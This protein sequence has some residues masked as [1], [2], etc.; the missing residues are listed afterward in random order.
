MEKI[1]NDLFKKFEKDKINMCRTFGGL[2]DDSTRLINT[3][4]HGP[5]NCT[6]TVTTTYD[7]YGAFI[8]SCENWICD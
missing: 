7:D 3:T 2:R 5:N 6:D 8:S 1:N 4:S